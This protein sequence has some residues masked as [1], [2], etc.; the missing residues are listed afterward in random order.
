MVTFFVQAKKVT[1]PPGM[2]GEARQGRTLGRA[3]RS[4]TKSKWIPA[5][6]G[7][8]EREAFAGMTEGEAVAGMTNARVRPDQATSITK[9]KKSAH[10]ALRP[11][12]ER[13][14]SPC[15]GQATGRVIRTSCH[16][17][18]CSYRTSVAV[19]IGTTVLRT[20]VLLCPE[21]MKPV[22]VAVALSLASTG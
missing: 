9:Q 1:R 4:K 17:C 12:Q 20:A 3:Q 11:K 22:R 8:T 10:W 5:F 2:A 14:F 18:C 16:T 15:A 6:A 13:K 21:P 19:A 7:M